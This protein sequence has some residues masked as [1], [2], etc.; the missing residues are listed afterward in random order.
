MTKI[1]TLASE[2]EAKELGAA[3]FAAYKA[4]ELTARGAVALDIVL[5]TGLPA[6]PQITSSYASAP[7][8]E[9]VDFR[10]PTVE[11]LAKADAAKLQLEID[12]KAEAYPWP[13]KFV[14]VKAAARIAP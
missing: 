6:V 1:V 4:S 13:A 11:E 14:A 10:K 7:A 8:V 12:A 9:F 5:A 3:I 2:A